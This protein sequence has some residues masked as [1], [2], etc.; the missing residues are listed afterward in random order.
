MSNGSATGESATA[1]GVPSYVELVFGVVF[2]WGFGDAL[3]TLVA[4]ASTGNIALETNP[5]VRS[6]LAVHPLAFVVLKGV[7]ALVVG[8]VLLQYR[9]LVEA[10][11]G[12]RAWLFLVVGAGSAVAGINVAVAL[13]AMS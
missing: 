2:V 5:V 13:L 11:P 12:W 10:V 6:I 3:S 8:L 4:L 7:V 9:P 1:F